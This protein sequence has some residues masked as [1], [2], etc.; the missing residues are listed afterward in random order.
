MINSIILTPNISNFDI[1][2]YLFW[3]YYA[4]YNTSIYC[5]SND[6]CEIVCQGNACYQMNL[7]CVDNCNISIRCDESIVNTVYCPVIQNISQTQIG[8]INNN[9]DIVNGHEIGLETF[10]F[11]DLIAASD[12][13][14]EVCNLE[15]SITFDEYIEDCYME[16]N[17]ST[18]INANFSDMDGNICCRSKCGCASFTQLIINVNVDTN[19]YTNNIVCSGYR[20]CYNVG[21]IELGSNSNLFCSG[22]YSCYM[23]TIYGN[24][25]ECYLLHWRHIVLLWIESNLFCGFFILQRKHRL[26]W[27][28]YYWCFKFYHCLR[29]F[30][31]ISK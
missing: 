19:G 27:L 14:E 21:L 29:R 8:E 4:A 18:N 22:F 15:T 30:D 5:F 10:N 12:I 6:N 3:G 2:S 26:R 25:G 24:L 16:N 17:V 28:Q 1:I 20:S 11:V 13:N 23:T 31:S 9:V 7:Y